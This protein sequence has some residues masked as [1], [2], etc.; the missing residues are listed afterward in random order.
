MSSKT[1]WQSRLFVA[2]VMP[3]LRYHTAPWSR[4]A[5]PLSMGVRCSPTPA[6]SAAEG[7]ALIQ[8]FRIARMGRFEEK[9][10]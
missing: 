9:R 7:W 4:L 6:R 2:A 3:V 5:G 1:C 8:G 10:S